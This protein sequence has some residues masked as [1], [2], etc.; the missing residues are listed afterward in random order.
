LNNPLVGLVY[1]ED[2]PFR[3]RM[4]KEMLKV[5]QNQYSNNED[6]RVVRTR[7]ILCPFLGDPN[8]RNDLIALFVEH[9]RIAD[10]DLA[11]VLGLDITEVMELWEARPISLFDCM[12][13]TCRAPIPVRNRKQLQRL[14]G[15]ERHF[16]LKVAAGDLI[17]FK[18]LREMLCESCAQGVQ[19]CHDEERRADVSVRRSRIA[20]TTKMSFKE[21]QRIPEWGARRNRVLIRAGY[22]CEL[23]GSRG[24]IDVHHKTYERYGDELLS[25]LIALCRPCHQKF[26]D[27][28][29]EMPETA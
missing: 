22:R 12:S 10:D 3:I 24:L 17:E 4:P 1:P 25:D 19:H 7:E 5:I 13:P 28:F 9:P 29:P 8:S 26:H 18:T 20:Q 27:I 6:A 23:C 14:I 15:V 11:D 21:Y 2:D 16:G